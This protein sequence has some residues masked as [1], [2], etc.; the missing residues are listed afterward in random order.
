M[1]ETSISNFNK[2][3]FS[4]LILPLLL[5][6]FIATFLYARDA[7]SAHNYI[8]IQKEAFIF[9]NLQLSKFPVLMY[10]FTQLGD[11]LIILSFFTILIF[12]APKM[13]EC[14]ISASLISA[15]LCSSLKW[16]FKIPRPAAVFE[17][18]S[19]VIIGK[20]YYGH[21]SLP[22]GHAITVFTTLT[23]LV[24]A[25]MPKNSN[26]KVIWITM[27]I[28]IGTLFSLSRVGIGAHYVLDVVIGSIIGYISG[29]SGII[30]SRHFK[31]WTFIG[32][33]QYYPLL[34]ILF[35]VCSLI[36]IRKMKDDNLPVFYFSLLSL[37]ISTYIITKN[38]VKK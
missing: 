38:Y 14:L 8:S 34:V 32:R 13:W 12:Y 29:V 37:F 22:S 18:D 30:V 3:K 11:A 33:K 21:N 6:T 28:G 9:F 5:L 36:V 35:I 17:K 7:W 23:V 19:F 4:Y 26:L 2:V 16:I 10:N 15:L 31:L 20:G 24:L 27:I 25:L 1:N